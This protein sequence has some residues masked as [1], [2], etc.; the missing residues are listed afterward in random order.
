MGCGAR[1]A[2]MLLSMV[3]Y[4]FLKKGEEC[5]I[6][7]KKQL[8]NHLTLRLWYQDRWLQFCRNNTI[9]GC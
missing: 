8:K 1:C 6:P 9:F 2:R 5:G 3:Q 4:S 7:F